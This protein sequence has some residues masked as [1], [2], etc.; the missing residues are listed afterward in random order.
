M[1]I[2]AVAGRSRPHP[3]LRA[4][5]SQGARGWGEGQIAKR[6]NSPHSSSEGCR[7]SGGVGC[8]ARTFQA[9]APPPSD[10]PPRAED[11]TRDWSKTTANKYFFASA[12]SRSTA[13]RSAASSS[14]VGDGVRYFWVDCSLSET[15]RVSACCLV[16]RLSASLYGFLQ[17]SLGFLQIQRAWHLVVRIVESHRQNPS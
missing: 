11:A 13:R 5:L 1:Q 6:V 14:V 10:T 7:I 8:P 2:V 3:A 16:A 4:T 17:V 9:T 12:S 15:D